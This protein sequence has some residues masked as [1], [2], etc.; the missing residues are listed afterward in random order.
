MIDLFLIEVSCDRRR[1]ARAYL[2]FSFSDV[3][4][5]YFDFPDKS[6]IPQTRCRVT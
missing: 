1:Q 6:G 5:M 3:Y 2:F 4:L